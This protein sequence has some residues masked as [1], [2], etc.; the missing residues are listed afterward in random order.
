MSN[1]DKT[2]EI[3]RTFLE[4]LNSGEL[5]RLRQMFHA[6][7]VWEVMPTGIPGV[8]KHQGR[9]FIIDEFLTPVRELF[10]P[11]SPKIEVDRVIGQDD[12][13]AVELRAN[14]PMRN[15]KQYSNKYCYIFEIMDGLVYVIREYMDSYYI[16]TIV[17][18]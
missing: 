10:E 9:D 11:G 16:S 17:A 2:E 8:G 7:A 6:E 5:G 4:T 18:D 3:V 14:G 15:G 12:V 13:A 1:S